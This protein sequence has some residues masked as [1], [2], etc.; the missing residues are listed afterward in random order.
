MARRDLL[1]HFPVSDTDQ[2]GYAGEGPE[3]LL[4]I[5]FLVFSAH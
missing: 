4:S 2:M 5:S 3:T 1:V